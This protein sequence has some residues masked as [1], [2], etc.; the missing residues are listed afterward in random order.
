MATRIRRHTALCKPVTFLR[1]GAEDNGKKYN[2]GRPT[3]R[4]EAPVEK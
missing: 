3:G 1:N 2:I 4:V